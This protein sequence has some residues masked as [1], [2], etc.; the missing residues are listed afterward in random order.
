LYI[1][2]ENEEDFWEREIP[3]PPGGVLGMTWF[4][5]VT[6]KG[7]RERAMPALFSPSLKK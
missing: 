4:C 2:N 3:R 6:G 5:V 1:G 7:R